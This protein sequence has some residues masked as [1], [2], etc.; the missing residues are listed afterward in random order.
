MIK[1][2]NYQYSVIIGIVLSDGGLALSPRGI[3][4][5]LRFKQSLNKSEYVWFVFSYLAHYCSSLPYLVRGKRAETDI[6]ALEFYTRALPCIN[7]VYSIFTL[8]ACGEEKKLY[9]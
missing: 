7:E 2:P 9:L 8:S 1:L 5:S 6:L 3:N 4:R